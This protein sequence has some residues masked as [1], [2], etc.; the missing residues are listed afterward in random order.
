MRAFCRLPFAVLL[1]LST[2][3]AGVGAACS[4]SPSPGSS[5]QTPDPTPE[6]APVT[7]L[8]PAWGPDGDRIAFAYTPSDA[9]SDASAYDQ[10]AVVDV[11]LDA[12]ADPDAIRVIAPGRVTR[13]DWSADGAWFA[14]HTRPPRSQIVAVHASGDSVQTLTGPDSPN[15]SMRYAAS[16][17]WA[18]ASDRLLFALFAGEPRGVSLMQA[19]GSGARISVPY[20]V[21]PA[22]FPEGER[23]TYVNWNDA[24]AD[25]NRRAQLYAANVDGSDVRRLTDLPFTGGIGEPDV[26]PDGTQIAFVN[27]AEDGAGVELHVMDADGTAVEQVTD[28]PGVV[29]C[30]RWHPSGTAIVFERAVPNV[31]NRLYLFHLD[32]R[33]VTPVFPAQAD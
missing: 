22:W 28:G 31:S 6:S 8:C 27:G 7:G 16:A 18:P 30:P 5:G 3:F 4:W 23:M 14:F 10:L 29:K 11:S 2:L 25:P 32:G 24:E 1:A 19:D 13:P 12:G 17:R 26:S 20:G 21:N 33:S 9:G 15:P